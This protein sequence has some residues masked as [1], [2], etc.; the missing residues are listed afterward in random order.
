MHEL[1]ISCQ[2]LLGFNH[3]VELMRY[4]LKIYGTMRGNQ[5]GSHLGL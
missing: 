2:S 3:S 5:S 1:K 4:I